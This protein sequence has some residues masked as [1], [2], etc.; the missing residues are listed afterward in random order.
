MIDGAP[1]DAEAL[2]WTQP[3]GATA[4]LSEYQWRRAVLA[5]HAAQRVYGELLEDL[6]APDHLVGRA[7]LVLW[8]A[9]RHRDHLLALSR[10]GA[11]D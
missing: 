1:T 7:W 10:D 4:P 11:D 6:D 5:V 8:R 2:P 3:A 9:E